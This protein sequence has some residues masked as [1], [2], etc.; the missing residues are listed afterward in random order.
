MQIP[1]RFSVF[2][3]NKEGHWNYPLSLEGWES[4]QDD[5]R[6]GNFKIILTENNPAILLSLVS[7][8]ELEKLCKGEN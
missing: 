7:E 5:K 3:E 6:E 8:S 4:F 1:R 2:Y